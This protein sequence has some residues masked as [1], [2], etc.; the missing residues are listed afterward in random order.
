MMAVLTSVLEKKL[1]REV[2]A[3]PFVL[4]LIPFCVV[5]LWNQATSQRILGDTPG[6]HKMQD[7]VGGPGFDSRPAEP[8]ASE[9]LRIY[10]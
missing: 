9:R 1:P 7:V 8:K 2:I 3:N 5:G 6:I 10:L 4:T